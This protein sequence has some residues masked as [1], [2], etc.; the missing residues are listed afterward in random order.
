MQLIA[1]VKYAHLLFSF[2]FV[3]AL[4]ATHWNVLAARRTQDW[5]VRAALFGLNQRISVMF[6]LGALLGLGLVGNFLAMQMGYSMKT[7]AVFRIVNGLWLASMTL[8]LA[9]DLP[10]SMK[11]AT[12]ARSAAT[13]PNGSDPV[14]WGNTLGRWRVGNAAQLLLFLS[15]LYFMVSPWQ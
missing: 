15:L 1:W 2:V 14:E 7:T 5:T 11:L 9:V 12:L 8:S 3:A 13:G 6:G 10:A 4:F